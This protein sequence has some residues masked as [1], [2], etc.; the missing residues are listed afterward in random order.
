VKEGIK[1]TC[2]KRLPTGRGIAAKLNESWI[3]II[4]APSE[5]EKKQEREHFY[6]K[7]LTHI[8]PMTYTDRIKAGDCN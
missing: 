2:L 4:Y 5:V 6:N 3:V 7:D 1:V 8:I